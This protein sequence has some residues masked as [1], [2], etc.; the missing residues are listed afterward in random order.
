[1]HTVKS[2]ETLWRISR[3]YSITVAALQLANGLAS[4]A[5]AAGQSLRI[6]LPALTR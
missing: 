2:G 6:P 5:V 4:T 1:M 3:T